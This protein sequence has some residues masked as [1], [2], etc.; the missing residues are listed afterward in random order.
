MS[1]HYFNACAIKDGIYFSHLSDE[2]K[3]V[4][5]PVPFNLLLPS[6]EYLMK[7]T[8]SIEVFDPLLF[9]VFHML[10]VLKWLRNQKL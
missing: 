3:P 10:T 1:L 5:D 4:P 8:S 2:V 6:Q 7:V 9:L